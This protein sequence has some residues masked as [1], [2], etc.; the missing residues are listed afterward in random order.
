MI[1]IQEV[2]P[3]ILVPPNTLSDT[4]GKPSKPYG[5]FSEHWVPWWP[6]PPSTPSWSSFLTLTSQLP[7]ACHPGRS[8]IPSL[9]SGGTPQGSPHSAVL[10]SGVWRIHPFTHIPGRLLSGETSL[11]GTAGK[12]QR[13]SFSSCCPLTHVNFF[14]G[15][16]P[17][18]TDDKLLR[19]KI[20]I[21]IIFTGTTQISSFV[22]Q[23]QQ[24]QQQ[25]PEALRRAK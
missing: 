1:A 9:L 12:P 2:S 18:L 17:L 14:C 25:T 22:P 24:Q 7:S 13:T 5:L 4:K 10:F 11:L 21:K 3:I 8:L 19:G 15:V 20:S 23:K 6:W 16:S